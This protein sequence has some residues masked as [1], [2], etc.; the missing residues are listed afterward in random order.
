MSREITKAFENREQSEG[1][2]ATVRRS[3]GSYQ[4]VILQVF[5]SR[6]VTKF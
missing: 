6:V 2:G 3:I 4:V 1:E 5:S